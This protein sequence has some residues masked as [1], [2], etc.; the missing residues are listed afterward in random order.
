MKKYNYEGFEFYSHPPKRDA[1]D[2]TVIGLGI[3]VAV[4]ASALIVI[5]YHAF[6]FAGLLDTIVAK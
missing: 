5:G 2:K 4:I 1:F 3:A 6:Y